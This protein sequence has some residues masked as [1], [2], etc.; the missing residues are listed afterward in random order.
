[1]RGKQLL[2]LSILL[3]LWTQGAGGQP[4]AAAKPNHAPMI[5]GVVIDSLARRPLPDAWVQLVA[6]DSSQVAP[7]TTTSDSLGR[8]A[9]SD[10]PDGRY[11][12]GFFHPVLDTL[13]IELPI[14]VVTIG[15]QRAVR[16][17]LAIPSPMLVRVSICNAKG[18]PDQGGVVIGTVRDARSRAPVAG[19]K[20]T[21]DWL[22]VSVRLGGVDSYRPRQAVTTEANGWFALCNVPRGGTMFLEATRGDESTD[23]LELQV[24]NDGFVR[25]D[26]FLGRVDAMPPRDTTQRSDSAAAAIARMRHGDGRLGGTIVAAETHVPLASAIV[27]IAEGPMARADDRGAWQLLRVP[28]GSRMFEARAVGFY[29][30]RRIVD[31]IDGTPAVPLALSTFRAVLDT[32][33][34]VASGGSMARLG[35]F[36]DRR[37]SGIGQ[38]ITPR[39]MERLG[40]IDIGDVFKHL[41]G[42]KIVTD[43][44]G[45][46][47]IVVRDGG[48]GFCEPSFY[49]DGMYTFTLSLDE[50]VGMV[51]LRSVQGIEVYDAANVPPQFRQ[52]VDFVPG[53]SLIAPTDEGARL[54]AALDAPQPRPYGC[55]AVLIWTK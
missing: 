38:F 50:V 36:S 55:G 40:V 45:M 33:R 4:P 15:R 21:A 14:Q 9:F 22:E 16:M 42:V 5:T 43:S 52:A 25:R 10:V 11:H 39:D 47:R 17:D 13:G 37:R 32:V 53:R 8:Y 23:H 12:I 1:M 2:A 28:T 18:V 31:V 41:H 34:V 7:Q 6:A 29:P 35:G 27:R 19:A 30:D 20:V 46:T 24:P 26:L 49:V 51:R 44:I 48:S 54:A 3:A